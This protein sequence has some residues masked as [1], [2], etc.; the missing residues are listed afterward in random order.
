MYEVD[1]VRGRSILSI[2]H[3]Q[4]T[5][6]LIKV[7]RGYIVGVYIKNLDKIIA[8]FGDKAGCEVLQWI[9]KRIS[10]FS[11][12]IPIAFEVNLLAFILDTDI[13]KSELYKTISRI[14]KDFLIYFLKYDSLYIS[15]NF[16]TYK[17]KEKT[18][19]KQV[20]SIKKSVVIKDK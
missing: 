17:I 5:L 13:S 1:Q 7:T 3:D 18:L 11:F 20:E 8:S 14:K 12:N 10:D 19:F 16:Q 6:K 15:I 2:F 9:R 4:E